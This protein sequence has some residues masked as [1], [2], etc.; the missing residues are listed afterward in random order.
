M[1]ALRPYAISTAVA[2]TS[3]LI[4]TA[5]LQ[6]AA[7]AEASGNGPGSFVV[8]QTSM[9]GASEPVI[10][11][12]PPPLPSKPQP[13][14]PKFDYLP[15]SLAPTPP[16]PADEPPAQSQDSEYWGGIGFTADGSWSTVWKERSKGEAEAAVAKG[17]A[18]FGH[19]AC[20][21]I[22]FTGQNCAALATFNG[23]YRGRRWNL[24]YTDGGIT[25]PDAQRAALSRCNSDERTRGNCQ[26]RTTVCADGR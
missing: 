6:R 22:S 5:P 12:P 26:I 13:P 17:C 11:P 2:I 23:S 21:V 25:Y 10:P 7:A 3:L 18:K 19:G 15:P 4:A 16:V 24:S 14:S 20:E 8:A 9:G 1:H